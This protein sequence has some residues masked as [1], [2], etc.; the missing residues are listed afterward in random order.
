MQVLYNHKPIRV[1]DFYIVGAPRSGTTALYSVLSNHPQTCMPLEKEPM[2]FSLWDQPPFYEIRKTRHKLSWVKV[3]LDEYLELF[4]GAKDG[5]ILGEGSTWYLYKHKTV[6]PNI[7]RL[8]G[9]DFR[10]IKIIILLRNP[11][12]RAWSQYLAKISEKVENLDFATAIKPE[13]IQKRQ[14]DRLT[15]TYD[16]MGV[17]RYFDQVKAYLDNF[18]KVKIYFYEEM[19]GRENADVSPVLEFLGLDFNVNQALPKVVNPSGI[20]SNSFFAHA[21]NLFFSNYGLKSILKKAVPPKMRRDIKLLSKA[22]M[23]RKPPIDP[24][25]R[26]DLLRQYQEDIFNLQRLL[27]KDLSFW[28]NDKLKTH[29]D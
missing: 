7:K 6:I 29:D 13:T 24:V 15:P 25:I 12:E 5:Q 1:P 14:R 10:K 22:R 18:S 17:S 8:Y 26:Q 27:D 20:P 3:T 11:A 28:F 23:L 19:F 9:D 2:F 16:Y 21:M 4:S